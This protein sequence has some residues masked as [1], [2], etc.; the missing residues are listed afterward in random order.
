MNMPNPL[1]RLARLKSGPA[2]ARSK[3]AAPP[4]APPGPPPRRRWPRPSFLS[5]LALAAV[6][7][8]GWFG[9]R[10]DDTPPCPGD[11]A[12]T[13][14]ACAV[15]G[16]TLSLGG[17]VTGQRCGGGQLVRLW[18]INAPESG[19]PGYRQ[20]RAAL[21]S[22]VKG[23]TVACQRIDTDD[24]NR[25][26]ARCCTAKADLSHAQARAGWAWD[27]VKYSKG[28]FAAAEADAKRDGLGIWGKGE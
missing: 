1:A 17:H 19:T 10:P 3:R 24:H 11:T 8:A 4:P 7:A 16:D 6:I 28:A 13:G 22:L 9:T 26:V 12:L 14:P 25:P 5:A 18:G 15:D 20:S 21:Q 23:R 27:Y 2:P